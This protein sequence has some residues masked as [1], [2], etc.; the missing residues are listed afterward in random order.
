VLGLVTPWEL[1]G[2]AGSDAQNV[3]DAARA[4]K[5]RVVLLDWVRY[6]RGHGSWF[7]PDG[8]HLTFSGARAFARLFRHALPFAQPPP[9]TPSNTES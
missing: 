8:C 1:G 9:P 5:K 6:S 4:Y 2:Y 3:R 7:Q